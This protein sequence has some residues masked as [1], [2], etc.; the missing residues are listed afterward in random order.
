MVKID[1]LVSVRCRGK[2]TLLH[3]RLRDKKPLGRGALASF[4]ELPYQYHQLGDLNNRYL[5]S[6]SSGAR[7]S[8]K[9]IGSIGSF[10]GL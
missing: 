10:L 2:V 7:S 9:G 8:K 6:H 3:G 1:C 4:L 5:L